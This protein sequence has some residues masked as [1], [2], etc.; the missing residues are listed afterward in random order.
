[1]QV[2]NPG[3][4]ALCRDYHAAGAWQVSFGVV[5]YLEVRGLT[6]VKQTGRLGRELE[7]G[8]VEN[9]CKFDLFDKRILEIDTDR[10]GSSRDLDRSLGLWCA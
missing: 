4:E 9:R 1:M 3:W 10:L 7:V 8:I 6:R 2:V 5:L